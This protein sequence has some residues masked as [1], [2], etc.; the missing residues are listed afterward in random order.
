MGQEGRVP[1][2]PPLSLPPAP[3]PHSLCTAGPCLLSGRREALCV[4]VTESPPFPTPPL[5]L[6]LSTCT[7]QSPAHKKL[8]HGPAG[9]RAGPKRA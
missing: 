2:R 7:V 8:R 9:L 4:F 5:Y 3:R 1:H 6:V